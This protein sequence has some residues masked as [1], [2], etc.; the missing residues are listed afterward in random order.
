MSAPSLS[1]RLALVD[2]NLVLDGHPVVAMLVTVVGVR[3]E[4]AD[5]RRQ[6]GWHSG[7]C[8]AALSRIDFGP[9]ACRQVHALRE[10][11]SLIV[12]EH[13]AHAVGCPDCRIRMR[14]AFPGSVEVRFDP[15]LEVLA[16]CLRYIQHLSTAR[17]RALH[18]VSLVTGTV[19]ALCRRAARAGQ[20]RTRALVMPVACMDKTGLRVAGETVR[21][22]VIC[23]GELTFYRL[24][25]RGDI[26]KG[27][28]V[29][30]AVYDCF[31]PY[32]SQLP[33][34][35]L[36][37]SCN[38]YLLR[39]LEEIVELEKEPDGRAARMQRLLLETRDV[40][41]YWGE[42]T[43]GPVPEPIRRETA[44]AG[45]FAQMRGLIE[46]ARKQGDT[47]SLTSCDWILTHLGW[48]PSR[49]DRG[50]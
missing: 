20:L 26:W 14:A 37:G 21:L 44:M 32:L 50:T 46:T 35:T 10:P 1:D 39:N 15:R 30:T 13:Q 8:G 7:N 24:G 3:E 4:I 34:E 18:G 2:T 33:E 17:L 48:T 43:G 36:Q 47:I 19:E 42:A 11:P 5:L 40:T 12:T 31:T 49:P 27:R 38:A 22:Y 45:C 9:S 16:A 6:L 23:D 29:G 28:R 25:G 41:T